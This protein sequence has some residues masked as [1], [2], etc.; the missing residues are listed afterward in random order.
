[1]LHGVF[2]CLS[3]EGVL[4]IKKLLPETII[5]VNDRSEFFD[6]RNRVMGS[7]RKQKK[8][9]RT[10]TVVNSTKG[11]RVFFSRSTRNLKIQ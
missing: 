3:G 10:H 1:M 8:T 7:H 6:D 11:T 2:L 9:K 5:Y 4:M